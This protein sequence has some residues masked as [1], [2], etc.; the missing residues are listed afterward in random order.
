MWL[1]IGSCIFPFWNLTLT[2]IRLMSYEMMTITFP[3]SDTLS[4]QAFQSEWGLLSLSVAGFSRFVFCFFFFI[5]VFPSEWDIISGCQSGNR[6]PDILIYTQLCPSLGPSI[7][8]GHLPHTV[9]MFAVFCWLNMKVHQQ[10]ST[11]GKHIEK[12]ITDLSG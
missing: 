6:W 5:T 9:N 4:Y 10:A 3:C 12:S 1:H 11:Q 7:S 8:S 2:Y